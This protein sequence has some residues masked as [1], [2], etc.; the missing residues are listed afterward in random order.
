MFS[1]NKLEDKFFIIKGIEALVQIK[2]IC[3]HKM[4]TNTF[5]H[6]YIG[7]H[8]THIHTHTQKQVLSHISYMKKYVCTCTCMYVC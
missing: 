4:Y 8:D 3:M 6:V 5:T 1:K 2:G 7:S